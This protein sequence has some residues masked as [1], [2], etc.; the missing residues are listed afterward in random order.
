MS[1]EKIQYSDL[2]QVT[3]KGTCFSQ[4]LRSQKL[5]TF[6]SHILRKT[7]LI[8]STP[9]LGTQ[10]TGFI[11]VNIGYLPE[12]WLNYCHS[13]LLEV[14]RLLHT[15]VHFKMWWKCRQTLL[16]LELTQSQDPVYHVLAST[17]T[18]SKWPTLKPD[19]LLLII[20]GVLHF[21]VSTIKACK[22]FEIPTLDDSS[23]DQL[24]YKSYRFQG[25][26]S[27]RRMNT[28]WNALKI[29]HSKV[30][31]NTATLKQTSALKTEGEAGMP[32]RQW[33]QRCTACT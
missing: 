28:H 33:G 26:M 25:M 21:P 18:N 6:P 23:Q 31:Y 3:S 11:R 7:C 16:C 30:N 5:F 17:G 10:A 19:R 8:F 15:S 20:T 22:F 32:L 1:E 14:T 9:G 2:V 29:S 13:S 24:L 4:S 27:S 12:W